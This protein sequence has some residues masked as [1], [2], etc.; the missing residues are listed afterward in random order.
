VEVL[1]DRMK[2]GL[3]TPG[4]IKTDSAPGLIKAVDSMG[5]RS[6]RMRCWLQ[7]MQHLM[8]KVPPPAWPACTA[9]VTDLRDAPTFEAGHRRFQALLV[10]YQGPFP[11]ACRC[12]ADDAEASLKH[13]KVPMRHRQDVRT[14]HLAERA[15]EEERRRTKVM[16]H[17]WDEAS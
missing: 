15:C 1:R 14:S 17:R 5:L 8:Q 13:L 3:Q 7:K 9:L 4:T 11:E 16:P 2:R 6:L 10:H 12:L